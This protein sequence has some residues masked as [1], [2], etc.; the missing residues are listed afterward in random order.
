MDR[1]RDYQRSSKGGLCIE[2]EWGESTKVLIATW[3][4]H[5]HQARTASYHPGQDAT[6]HIA[7]G[8][9]DSIKGSKGEKLSGY[10][11]EPQL[12]TG[13]FDAKRRSKRSY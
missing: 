10:D 1:Q 9:V 6:L 13:M 3:K 12:V 7:N 4:Y 5:R 2:R 8:E 11:L